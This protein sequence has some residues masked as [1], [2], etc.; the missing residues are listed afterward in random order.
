MRVPHL[1]PRQSREVL[2]SN[3]DKYSPLRLTRSILTS[4]YREGNAGR[5]QYTRSG[6]DAGGRRTF[7]HGFLQPAFTPA[8]QAGPGKRPARLRSTF[9]SIFSFLA[10]RLDQCIC[11]AM[12]RK[13][14]LRSKRALRLRRIEYK[15]KIPRRPVP[16]LI[17]TIGSFHSA[18]FQITLQWSHQH[19]VRLRSLFRVEDR[20]YRYLRLYAKSYDYEF[21]IRI[22]LGA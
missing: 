20:K 21:I 7:R 15:A 14:E 18:A 1:T 12:A 5:G 3:S 9:S 17:T 10:Q 11:T 19:F 6:A 16:S 13:R 4:D 8:F 22:N 2:R